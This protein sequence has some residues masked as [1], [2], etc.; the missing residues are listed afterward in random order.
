MML[1]EKPEPK[2][3]VTYDS[4]YLKFKNKQ[5]DAMVEKHPSMVESRLPRDRQ[6]GTGCREAQ[7]PLGELLCLDWEQQLY[8]QIS[9]F[10]NFVATDILGWMMV[11]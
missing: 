1:N 2:G 8:E 11:S 6:W 3:K 10:L 9:G 7:E 4:V 5:N